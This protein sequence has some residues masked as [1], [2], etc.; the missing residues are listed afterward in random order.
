MGGKEGEKLA[1][2]QWD[3]APACSIGETCKPTCDTG[4]A[5]DEL[6]QQLNA[7]VPYELRAGMGISAKARGKTTGTIA[8]LQIEPEAG[9]VLIPDEFPGADSLTTSAGGDSF[10]CDDIPLGKAPP[11]NLRM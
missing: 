3:P 1:S 4:F 11:T 8:A 5:D 7:T 6:V 10:N 2:K 9:D